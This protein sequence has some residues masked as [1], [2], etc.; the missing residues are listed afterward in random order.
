M[1]IVQVINDVR[2]AGGG[3]QIL[4]VQLHRELLRAGDE[5]QLITLEGPVPPGLAHADSLSA[6][7]AHRPLAAARVARALRRLR[8]READ[9]VHA[10]LFPT[11]AYVAATVDPGCGRP[12]LVTTEH[13]SWNRRHATIG[14]RLFDVGMYRRY[15]RIVAVSAA[16]RHSLSARLGKHAPIATVPNG[17]EVDSFAGVG[18][19]PSRRGRRPPIILMVGRLV[20]AKDHATALRA[21]ALVRHPATIWIAGV[22][23]LEAQLRR[24][25]HELGVEGR[26]RFLGFT[27]DVPALLAQSE[28]VLMTSRWE[29]FGLAVAE[30]MAAGRPVVASDV[31]GLREVLGGDGA[32]GILVPPGDARAVAGALDRLLNDTTLRRRLGASGRRRATAFSI[33]RTVA[34]YRAVYAEAIAE[35][36]P[37][38]GTG[39]GRR[40]AQNVC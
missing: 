8:L 30:A 5:A 6:P 24:L 26:V 9:V 39:V 21:F 18:D 19:P 35:R 37:S 20:E 25:A 32:S 31:P 13:S 4:A 34:G 2:A 22:G 33:E 11:Q 1:R 38:R 27:D 16:A 17:I 12:A 23:P 28:V 15:D 14:G 40:S 10:H 3:A 29:G 7:N 36:R